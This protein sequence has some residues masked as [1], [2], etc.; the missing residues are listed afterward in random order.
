[1][2]KFNVHKGVVGCEKQLIMSTTRGIA[3]G[4]F[5][6]R[7]DLCVKLKGVLRIGLIFF[8]LKKT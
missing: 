8:A 7:Q 4:I 3:Q 2:L 5:S 1:M 6:K